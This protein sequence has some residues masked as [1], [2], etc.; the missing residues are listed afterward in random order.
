MNLALGL[1]P[2]V[3]FQRHRA[4]MPG[5]HHGRGQ[6]RMEILDFVLAA[7]AVRAIR[8]MDLTRAMVFRAIQRDEQI[9]IQAAH[10]LQCAGLA[11]FGHDIGEQRV[12]MRWFDRIEHGADPDVAGD[13]VHPEQR[14][15][16]GTAL[17][18]FQMA[19]MG[20]EGRALHE[21]RRER[22]E[23][24]V[25]HRI[26]RVVPRTW[27]WQGLATAAQRGDEAAWN[28]HGVLES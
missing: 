16:I 9:P 15:A 13:F 8:A 27:V 6:H 12:E 23:R 22:G 21:E 17:R 3:R 2:R 25:R 28:G 11:Q 4:I 24:E 1:D 26:A 14:L 5:R 10:G 19:L 7:F 20:Q 18:Y